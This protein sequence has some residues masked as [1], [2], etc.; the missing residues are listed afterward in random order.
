MYIDTVDDIVKK[1]NSTY[2]IT[3][4]MKPVDVKSNT[5]IGFHKKNDEEGPKFEVCDHVTISKYTKLFW[6]ILCLKLVRRSVCD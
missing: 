1:Y 5:Y 3:I 2:H 4:K 6:K